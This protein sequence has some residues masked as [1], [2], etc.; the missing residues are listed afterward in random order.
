MFLAKHILF[1]ILTCAALNV[2]AQKDEIYKKDSTSIRCK[3][4]GIKGKNYT[5]AF[6]D[7]NNIVT[8]KKVAKTLVDSVQ[9]NK[10]D[11]NLVSHKLFN[12]KN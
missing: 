8:K 5:Y 9:Y 12:K 2:F 4:L 10:Y 7:K 1:C 11:S 6:A 3:V